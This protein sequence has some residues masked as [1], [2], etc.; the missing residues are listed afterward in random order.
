MYHGCWNNPVSVSLIIWTSVLLRAWRLQ[1]DS[2]TRSFS[3]GYFIY[4]KAETWKNNSLQQDEL[5]V[6]DRLYFVSAFQVA[7]QTLTPADFKW[8][9]QTLNRVFDLQPECMRQLMFSNMT[10]DEVAIDCEYFVRKIT[11]VIKHLIKFFSKI[12]TF[13]SHSIHFK[14]K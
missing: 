4:Q 12:H 13:K 7:K 5:S 9:R 3:L 8:S 2:R 6:G 14:W 11:K 1:Y 10:A